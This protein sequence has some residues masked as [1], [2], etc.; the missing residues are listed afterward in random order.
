MAPKFEDRLNE[1]D[2]EILCACV[3]KFGKDKTE[4]RIG[5]TRASIKKSEISS[6]GQYGP[7]HY[8]AVKLGPGGSERNKPH[9]VAGVC[10]YGLLPKRILDWLLRLQLNQVGLPSMRC[11][12]MVIC[13][14]HMI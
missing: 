7:L 12:E 11:R 2:E 10:L 14:R 3:K 5:T 13:S 6:S 1:E 4:G 8:D 9:V